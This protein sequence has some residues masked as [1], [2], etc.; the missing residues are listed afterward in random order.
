MEQFTAFESSS[1]AKASYDASSEMLEIIFHTSDRTYQYLDVPLS[2]WE[3]FKRADSKGAY[4]N[5]F[6]KTYHQYV[7]V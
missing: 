3:D 2:Q 4:V 7:K 6:I 1:I 5:Q